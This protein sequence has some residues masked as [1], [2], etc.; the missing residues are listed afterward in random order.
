MKSCTSRIYGSK[1]T[2][3]N[4]ASLPNVSAVDHDSPTFAELQEAVRRFRD[5][6]DW[7]QFHTLKDLAAALAVEAG[8]LQEQLLWVRPEDERERLEARR[9]EI[10]AEL[11]DVV[12]LA[13]NFADVASIDL[14]E[15]IKSKLE[16]NARRYPADEVR[17]S[18]AKYSERTID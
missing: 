8:E 10:A 15:A 6:R 17:G 7:C 18:A 14:G 13:L 16:E 12:I 5:E 4:G 11:A 2:A 1:A 3:A 9:D